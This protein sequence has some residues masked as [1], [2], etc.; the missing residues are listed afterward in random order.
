MHRIALLFASICFILVGFASYYAGERTVDFLEDYTEEKTR[1]NVYNAGH[2][3]VDIRADGLLVH[4][5]GISPNEASRLKVL[6]VIRK[7][8]PAKRLR[9]KI[10][11]AKGKGIKSPQFILEMLR[12]DD[13]ISLIGLIPLSTGRD[14]ILDF[15][16]TV[17]KNSIVVD[18]LE[19]A[20]HPVGEEWKAA[21]QFA[22]ISMKRL[23]RSKISVSQER[24]KVTALT[25]SILEKANVERFLI[26]KKPISILLT[27][28]ISSPRPVISPFKFHMTL[29][30]GT[31][32]LIAC[33]ADTEITKNKILR[34]LKTTATLNQTNCA[35][36]LGMPTSD[37]V[38]VIE[39]TIGAL[40]ALGGGTLNITDSDI[41]LIANEAVSQI[42]FDRVIGKLENSLPDL[43]S[44]YPTLPPK[45]I[46]N[47]EKSNHEVIN[48]IAIKDKNGKLQLSGLIPNNTMKLATV[49]YAKSKFGT[50]NIIV[51]TRI[52]DTLPKDW[53]KKILGGLDALSKLHSGK[54]IVHTNSV[55]ITGISV[56]P[57][58]ASEISHIL[59]VRIGSKGNYK[60]AVKFDK[61][62][63][64]I[65]KSPSIQDCNQ[66]I[67]ALLDRNQISFDPSSAR[68][69]MKTS[70]I[71]KEIASIL[72]KCPKARFEIEGH[73]DS[74]GS[75]EIN[76]DI[77]QK[78]AEAI[79][80]ALIEQN[81]KTLGISAK[82]Y[83][84]S[85]PISNNNTQIGRSKNRRITFR[86]LT[87]ES[88]E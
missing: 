80:H 55:S 36:G 74:K 41:T 48:F 71:I 83:G 9:D 56:R 76:L 57:A 62:L 7:T 26:K 37:W 25:D 29:T 82:G 67:T 86:L 72:Q 70:G 73:T 23:P 8:V 49:S 65:G 21:L 3:W 47:G 78:R 5:E 11:I 50:E 28:N 81:I 24:V 31:I 2:N 1:K 42:D 34:I 15:A 20:D 58:I 40:D 19:T 27:T 10:I 33:S 35:I 51:Q 61:T 88:T 64:K 38:P 32:D 52:D 69:S 13:E 44:L 85:K 39:S 66:G 59:S 60:I 87:N 4:L 45:V 68:I 22:L 6:D 63:Y 12:N 79:L 54:L 30:N 43:F 75:D 77:S 18:M 46:A 17:S 53:P 14:H 16:S 84:S